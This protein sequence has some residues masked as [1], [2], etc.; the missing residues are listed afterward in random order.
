M[1]SPRTIRS[2]AAAAAAIGITTLI[3]PG[4]AAAHVTTEPEQAA[5][6]DSAKIAFR[7]PN[8]RPDASTVKVHVALPL[9]YPLSSVR[10]RPLPGW[11]AEVQKVRLPRP[12]DVAG[13]QVTE[14]VSGIT[15]TA[16]P[17]TAIGPDQFQDF[18]ASLGTLPTTTDRLLL[19]TE[20]TYDSGEVVRWDQLPAPDGSE[21]E[22]PA[23]ELALVPGEGGAGHQHG[24]GSGQQPAGHPADQATAAPATSDNTARALGG[25]GLVVGAL[26]LGIGLGALLRGRRGGRADS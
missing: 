3:G 13:A 20:Q 15:W 17:G 12:V 4:T 6:G 9:D 18:E 5:Q 2:I 8:E 25:A 26:G 10:T 16:L 11:T 1:N 24:A 23:P 14:A 7:V 19:P 22:H 21:P